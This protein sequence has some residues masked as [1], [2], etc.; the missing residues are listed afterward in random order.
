M[1]KC[2]SL[3]IYLKSILPT[4]EMDL[5]WLSYQ[6][7]ELQLKFIIICCAGGNLVMEIYRAKILLVR[8]YKFFYCSFI[9]P[10]VSIN[11]SGS[12]NKCKFWQSKLQSICIEFV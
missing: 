10:Y 11:S 1:K 4:Y 3:L 5:W 8:I 9:F 6:E 2:V 7:F 12:E